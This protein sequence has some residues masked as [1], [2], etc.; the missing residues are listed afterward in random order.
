[1]KPFNVKK[2]IPIALGFLLI[3]AVFALAGCG[4]KGPPVAPRQVPLPVVTDLH[5]TVKDDQVKLT[6]T[7]PRK[8]METAVQ[9][10]GFYVSRS[11]IPLAQADCADCPVRFD[12]IADIPAKTPVPEKTAKPVMTYTDTLEK[13]YRYIYKV[14]VYTPAEVTG[15]D[16]NSV[17]FIH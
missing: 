2:I 16:S 5:A 13:G 3:M 1:M 10:A 15:P 6:W 8:G 12:R 4:K 17:E 9:V 7:V 11:K 14:T